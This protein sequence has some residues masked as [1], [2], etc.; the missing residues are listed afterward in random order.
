MAEGGF[1]G[2]RDANVLE[3]AIARPWMTAFGEEAY[4][5]PY[6]KA[7]ALAEA[8]VCHHVFNDG[9]HRTAL[10][11]AY[12]LLDQF[13]LHL[14]TPKDETLDT[15]RRLEAGTMTVDEFSNWLELRCVLRLA[16]TPSP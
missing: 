10:G 15:I 13:G 16:D 7:A 2:T 8:I 5:T 1:P 12:I 14:T 6:Q 9:N 3:L 4:R 11:A